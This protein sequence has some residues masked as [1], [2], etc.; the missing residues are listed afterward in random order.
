MKIAIIGSINADLMYTIEK[1]LVQGETIIGDTYHVMSGGK[2]A[3]Q[4]VIANALHNNV[5]FLGARGDDAFGKNIISDLQEHKGLNTDAIITKSS[6]TG[7]AVIKVYNND[8][9]I[10]VFPGANSELTTDDIDQF[11]N[12]N[13][14]IRYVVSQME[15]ALDVVEYLLKEAHNRDIITIL[16]PAPAAK[17]NQSILE[18]VDYIIPNRLEANTLFNS[19]D[20]EQ[21]VKTHQG[22]LIITLGRDGVMI[23]HDS[24]VKTIPAK[25]IE[26]VDT[27]GAG[28][29]FVAGFTVGL[30]RGYDIKQAA[31]LGTE[32]AAITCQ[33]YGAQVGVDEINKQLSQ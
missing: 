16:N 13:P 25:P 18:N 5:V 20:Y 24:Q 19:Q 8:N 30:A 11:Y 31:E 23:F 1:E 21:L 4:A 9:S 22:Q 12:A 3:N 33:Y 15:I 29:A 7:L 32:V 27:T 10:V 2:G 28:D 6:N 14:D 17:I 26:S